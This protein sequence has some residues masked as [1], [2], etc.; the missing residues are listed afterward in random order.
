[1]SDV[2]ALALDEHRALSSLVQ[3]RAIALTNLLR[4]LGA[5]EVGPVSSTMT[6]AAA[7]EELDAL[8]RAAE[9]LDLD[10]AFE[11]RGGVQ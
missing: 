10:V 11:I 4:A 1:M 9:R 7:H 6:V 2:P 8:A 3:S 5:E